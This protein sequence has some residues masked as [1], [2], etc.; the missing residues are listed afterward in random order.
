MT[1]IL[2]PA[3]LPEVADFVSRDRQLLIGGAWVDAAS[4]EKFETVDPATGEVI[5]RVAKGTA[6]DIDRAV[7]PPDRR[8]R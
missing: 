4:G 8:R 1:A 5:T 7:A 2:T 6:E 3:L